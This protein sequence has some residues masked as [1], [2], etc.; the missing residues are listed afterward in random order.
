MPRTNYRKQEELLDDFYHLAHQYR[1]SSKPDSDRTLELLA[2]LENLQFDN[3]RNSRA[4]SS[5]CSSLTLLLYCVPG[6]YTAVIKKATELLLKYAQEDEKIYACNDWANSDYYP[7]PALN[8][9]LSAQKW[10]IPYKLG[11]YYN[12]GFYIALKFNYT[13]WLENFL[14]DFELD[15]DENCWL[16]VSALDGFRY[17]D[18]EITRSAKQLVERIPTHLKHLVLE[19]FA[20]SL[21]CYQLAALQYLA[22]QNFYPS[23]SIK[24][25]VMVALVKG[26]FFDKVEESYEVV[27]ALGLLLVGSKLAPKAEAV[28][29]NLRT[30]Q[31]QAAVCD[32]FLTVFYYE[33]PKRCGTLAVECDYVPLNSTHKALFFF[34]TGQF[35]RYDALDFDHCILRSL[36]ETSEA[37]MRQRIAQA[38]KES[39]NPAYIDILSLKQASFAVEIANPQSQI[40]LQVLKDNQ[41]WAV[42]WQKV[43]E[44]PFVASVSALGR[45]LKSGSGWQPA[46]PQE[47]QLYQKLAYLFR[48]KIAQLAQLKTALPVAVRLASFS[49]SFS[50]KL[51]DFIFTPDSQRLVMALKSGNLILWNILEGREEKTLTGP[52]YAS[53]H[54]CFSADGTL[55]CA[56]QPG[57]SECSS[58]VYSWS[59]LENGS[60]L[61]KLNEQVDSVKLLKPLPDKRLLVIREGQVPQVL[62]TS[63]GQVEAILPGEE[64]LAALIMPEYNA[65][66]LVGK[67]FYVFDL[68]SLCTLATYSNS[69]YPDME[70][71]IYVPALEKILVGNSNDSVYSLTPT[72]DPAEWGWL[73]KSYYSFPL[74]SNS[75][76]KAKV[77]MLANVP[78]QDW[79]VAGTR[80]GRIAFTSYVR[81]N[82]SRIFQTASHKLKRLQISPDG[83]LMALTEN[84]TLSL[85]DLCPLDI[86]KL[87]EQPLLDATAGHIQVL[88]RLEMELE[89]ETK[90]NSNKL[91]LP[92]KNSLAYIREILEYRFRYA[93]E[94]E[95]AP[96]VVA[97]NFDIEF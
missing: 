88:R 46:D 62:N 80:G 67:C 26:T 41:E 82:W 8:A 53:S 23:E 86:H 72:L 59:S 64:V 14:I 91:S 68:D 17:K 3:A 21:D 36:Y 43:L 51:N 73:I 66:A 13:E 94:I 18:C 74:S 44:L 81:E 16:L 49:T 83:Q 77:H 63:T 31:G 28:L 2:K 35:T 60:T 24:A 75:S 33:Y 58:A 61:C 45:L 69:R 32:L 37:Y 38:I 22:D 70:A 55:F 4:R 89:T 29:R 71:L 93:I 50:C 15:T 39:G 47:N 19:R 40:M 48:S 25:L 92:V 95:A 78:Q 20:K 12:A 54:L 11:F 9:L 90:E 57:N 76:K 84:P 52:G 7:G 34:L 56:E 65:L 5:V 6:S 42:L 79:L 87:L 30:K 96:L 10:L 85:W 1:I 97:G 27:K